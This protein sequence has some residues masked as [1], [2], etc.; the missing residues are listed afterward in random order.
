M[1]RNRQQGTLLFE[2]RLVDL[3]DEGKRCEL[4]Q[5][6]AVT[7]LV[8]VT[9]AKQLAGAAAHP[10]RRSSLDLQRGVDGGHRPDRLGLI[11]DTVFIVQG[12]QAV[13]WP[14]QP[15]RVESVEIEADPGL[16]G[17]GCGRRG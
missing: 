14:L 3:R 5:H 9:E 2:E 12:P 15:V 7:G 17:S 1:L 10:A 11:G 16:R 6:R 8:G 13:G 4:F